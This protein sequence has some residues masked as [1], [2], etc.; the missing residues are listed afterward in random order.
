ML[1]RRYNQQITYWPPVGQNGYGEPLFG[2]PILICGRW[3]DSAKTL[4]K[5]S[6][7]EVNVQATIWVDQ[8]VTIE[9]YLALDDWTTVADPTLAP[10]SSKILDTESIPSMRTNQTE[11]RAFV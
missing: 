4:R 11:R 7:E 3:E 9:G 6:S 5:G 1:N 2:T 10:G 8:A